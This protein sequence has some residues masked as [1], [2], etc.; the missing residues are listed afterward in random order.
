M[1]NKGKKKK[2]R[3]SRK[4]IYSQQPHRKKYLRSEI[5]QVPS[6]RRSLWTWHASRGGVQ[7]WGDDDQQGKTER[8]WKWNPR[9]TA[10]ITKSHLKVS[11]TVPSFLRWEASRLKL[12]KAFFTHSSTWLLR[13][14]V[15]CVHSIGCHSVALKSASPWN[16]QF[17]FT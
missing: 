17:T 13:C 7:R 2:I 14:L 11:G 10:P 3:V 9:W 8:Q 16:L 5:S 6:H 15:H 12:G 1:Q 4:E